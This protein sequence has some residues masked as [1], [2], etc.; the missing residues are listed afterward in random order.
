M[1][2]PMRPAPKTTMSS[3]RCSPWAMIRLQA[4]A[5]RGEAMTTMRSPAGS[6]RRRVGRSSRRPGSGPPPWSPRT[7]VA[8]RAADDYVGSR[9]SRDL[10]LDD[11]HLAFGEDVGLARR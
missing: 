4:R 5:E 2:V 6:A 7:G 1:V 3:I 11:L 10:E 9:S 8:Q